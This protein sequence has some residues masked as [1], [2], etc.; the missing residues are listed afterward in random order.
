MKKKPFVSIVVLTREREKLLQ[1]CIRSI[2]DNTY[3]NIELVILDNGSEPS[4]RLTRTFISSLRIQCNCKIN[5][6]ES[7]PK[8]FAEMRQIAMNN[9]G[10]EII[11]SIDD[12]CV[13]DDEAILQIVRRFMSDET[14]GIVGGNISNIGFEGDEQFKGRGRIGI[15]GRYEPVPDPNDAEVFGS[16]NM[17]I[18]REAF[19]AVGGYDLF[20]SGAFEE[21]DLSLRVKRQGY[22]VIY[23]PAAKITHFHSPTRFRS[24]W[25]NLDLLR[26][27]LF[28]KHYMPNNFMGW[29][30]FL[31]NELQLLIKQTTGLIPTVNVTSVARN[32]K[33]YSAVNENR[34]HVSK[35]LKAIEY[36]AKMAYYRCHYIATTFFKLI[37][38]R[39]MIPYLICRAYRLRSD[40]RKLG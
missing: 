5:Y 6:I 9:S 4:R 23:E 31:R 13:A 40:E 35:Y 14:V 29:N 34:R 2:L 24:K 3:K 26:L 32:T 28:F 20:F 38:A 33:S 30:E 12:D 39:M 8:G 21:A 1:Q 37:V 18:R 17:S 22:K 10:G 15:N 7:L 27:Y 25:R 19:E 11:M 36:I 16:A